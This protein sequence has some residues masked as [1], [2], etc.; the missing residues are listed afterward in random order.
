M[1]RILIAWERGKA[2]GHLARDIPI[3]ERL[4]AAGYEVIFAVTDLR[5]AGELLCPA[6]FSF[7]SA[8]YLQ[9]TAPAGYNPASYAEMMLKHGYSDSKVLRGVISAW[10]QIIRWLQPVGM[11]ADHAPSAL[12]AARAFSIPTMT[13]GTGWEVPPTTS[14]FPWLQ[15]DSHPDPARLQLEEALICRTINEALDYLKIP[16]IETLSD[17]FAPSTH[18]LTTFEELDQ[19]RL[20]CSEICFSRS[21]TSYVG[22]IGTDF[23]FPAVS[24]KRSRQSAP[25][26]FAYLR[27]EFD[28]A[29]LL[30]ALYV[31]ARKGANVVCAMPGA[32]DD[33]VAAARPLLDLRPYGLRLGAMLAEAQLFVGYGGAGAVSRALLA[34][35][36]VF[37]GPAILERQVT[38]ELA[39]RLGGGDYILKSAS[40]EVTA[41]AMERVINEAHFAKASSLFSVKYRGMPENCGVA[42]VAD[43]V[44]ELT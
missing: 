44:R 25:N 13:L 34:G 32:T 20:N 33:D 5:V 12:L 19:S 2:Y 31:M 30:E 23:A 41:M 38:A 3:A 36:P 8:P 17:I 7:V 21:G 26:I 11:I 4:R 35:V 6:G 22:Y 1:K 18:F 24:W 16:T 29:L 37:L 28:N 10:T 39:R 42:Y 40:A 14:P 9:S 15:F 43:R 27:P